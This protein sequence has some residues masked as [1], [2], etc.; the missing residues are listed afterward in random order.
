MFIQGLL[1]KD[2]I[3]VIKFQHDHSEFFSQNK[4]LVMEGKQIGGVFYV[5]GVEGKAKI[6]RARVTEMKQARETLTS[7]P[8]TDDKSK[9]LVGS[10]EN[11]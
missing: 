7:M 10:K 2:L 11:I 5:V 4:C 1:R 3:Y 9:K 6:R 8:Y